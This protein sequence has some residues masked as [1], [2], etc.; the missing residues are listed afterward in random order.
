MLA[1]CSFLAGSLKF[2]NVTSPRTIGPYT[3]KPLRGL[4]FGGGRTYNLYVR[5]I[6]FISY[7]SYFK[8]LKY[9]P[10]IP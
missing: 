7:S 6:Y 10:G 8:L 4:R 2:V 3:V 9:Y 5:M 1:I